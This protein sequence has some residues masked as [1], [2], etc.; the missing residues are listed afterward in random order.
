MDMEFENRYYAGR[1]MMAEFGRKYA[2]GP[3][4]PLLIGFWVLYLLSLIPALVA[5]ENFSENY[6]GMLLVLG[7]VMLVNSF[8]PQIYAATS[9]RNAKKLNEGIQ[10]ETVITFGETIELH[11]GM[12]HITVE[13]RKI[14][15]VVHLKHSYLLMI[16]KRN[17]VMLDP[18]GFTCGTFET[19]KDFLRSKRPDLKIPE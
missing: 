10:P 7:L 8:L 9:I 13:Y 5:P 4:M 15:R 12:I 17:A 3:R 2:V 16:G 18:E 11:E 19:F 6:R 1:K 14:L